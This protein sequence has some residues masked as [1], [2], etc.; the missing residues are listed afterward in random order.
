[1]I[2][3][4]RPL[5]LGVLALALAQGGRAARA[6]DGPTPVAVFR[7]DLLDTSLGG[8]ML[9]RQ[10]DDTARITR[11][12]EA[13]RARFAA[14]EHYRVV[15]LRPAAAA[16]ERV[17]DMHACGCDRDIARQ[18]GAEVSAVGWVQKVS[19]LILNMNLAVRRV[20][21]GAPL[22]G[23]SVDLRGNTDESWD[24][25]LRRLLERGDLFD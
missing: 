12:T 22:G 6:A 13:T 3:A 25:A 23:G 8:E 21:D 10:P 16:I 1:M 24:R 17:A 14:S 9:G 20:A 5:V 19:E 11:A 4:R 15:D 2:T 7:F 18:L